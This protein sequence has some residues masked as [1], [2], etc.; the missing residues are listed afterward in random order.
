MSALAELAGRLQVEV[1]QQDGVIRAVDT[2]LQRPLAQLSRLLVGQ[3]AEA[4]LARLPLLFS[5][6]AAAQQVAALRA[7][8][9]AACWPA[10]PEVEEGRARLAEL[11]LIRESLLR[12]VQ[13]WALPLPLERLKALVALCQRAAARLQPLTVFRAS[14]LP[15]DLQLEETLAELAAI[16]AHLE[17][18]APADWLGPRLSRW[19][20]VALGGPL[21]AV[22]DPADLPA[23][24]AQLRAG[25]A[26][27]EIAGAPRITGPAAAAGMQAT[28][29]AQ[30]EQHVGALLR[31]TAQA[32]D[33][34]QQP[35][36]PP[37]VAGL[38]AGEGVGL[39]QTARGALLHRVCLDEGTVGAWQLL[40]PT[41]WNF[42]EDGPLR[43]RLCGVRVAEEDSEALLRALILAV[44]PCVAF[45]VKIIHA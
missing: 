2:C 15:A 26:R 12:L 37:A 11:E 25:D 21:P 33:S 30:I 20:E 43:R 8:E 35:P 29:A 6:C 42:H 1:R 10:V 16:W 34:L 32:I 28:A 22:F 14:P 40:A 39:A 24:L 7:L 41:D 23:L 18:P 38:D 36:L 3:T 17:L 13:V 27:A 9:R 44:D 4:A 45:E 5:L 19:Q 31:R